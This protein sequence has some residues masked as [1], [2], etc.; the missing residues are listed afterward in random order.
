[1]QEGPGIAEGPV[2]VTPPS[3]PWLWPPG[4]LP[5]ARASVD[6][7]YPLTAAV[8]GACPPGTQETREFACLHEKR[9][10]P[11][12]PCACEYV[13]APSCAA[14][15]VCTP[16]GAGAASCACHAAL[17]PSADGCHWSGLVQN[18]TFDGAQGWDL[19]TEG[20]EG[21]AVTRIDAGELE[22]TV[23]Q[24][25]ALAWAGTTARLPA[26]GQFPGGAALVFDYS[27]RGATV[28][29]HTLASA[30]IDGFV[31]GLPLQSG[32]FVA[33]LPLQ[34]AERATERRCAALRERPSLASLEFRVQ[35]GGSCGLPVDY[36]LS[37]D[38]VRLEADAS[39]R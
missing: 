1:V 26:R 12:P 28:E 22:L 21:A 17:E 32:R 31:A 2:A 7:G 33:G 8:D 11:P 16:D 19:Q 25:C 24:R 4:Q 23:N 36:A 15:E 30:L 14:G 34:P 10:G 3:A 29:T 5:L 27:A 39:C 9:G 18:S 38:N 20:Q 6:S 37:V 13:C 35:V